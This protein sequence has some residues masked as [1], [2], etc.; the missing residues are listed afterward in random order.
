M[1]NSYTYT[2]NDEDGDPYKVTFIHNFCGCQSPGCVDDEIEVEDFCGDTFRMKV[3]R[4]MTQYL[5][6]VFDRSCEV[7][8]E[9][10]EEEMP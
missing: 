5:E 4:L 8:E 10:A 2:V 9:E 3:P 7:I 6:G 1:P